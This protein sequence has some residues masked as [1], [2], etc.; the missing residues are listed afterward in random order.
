[1]GNIGLEI[2]ICHKVCHLTEHMLGV[3]IYSVKVSRC[4]QLSYWYFVN[5]YI[6]YK[7]KDGVPIAWIWKP[8]FSNSTCL[9]QVSKW[10][11]AT[12]NQILAIHVVKKNFSKK[13]QL[14]VLW[15]ELWAKHKMYPSNVQYFWDFEGPQKLGFWW[16]SLKIPSLLFLCCHTDV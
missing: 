14:L 13:S 6:I 2:I 5:L 3:V 12:G 9:N 4:T 1:M 10:W 8:R 7:I 11:T 16:R 15:T